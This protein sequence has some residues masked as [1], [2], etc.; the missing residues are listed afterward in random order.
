MRLLSLRFASLA[1]GL[2]LLPL[3]ALCL[4]CGALPPPDRTKL[5]EPGPKKDWAPPAVTT[6]DMP[7]GMKVWYLE[8]DQAPLISLQLVFTRGGTS[9]PVGKEGLTALM[10][11]MLDEGAGER[12]ALELSEAWQRLATDFGLGTDTDAV[13]A[14]LDMLADK[15]EPSL[16][17]LADVLRKPKLPAQ[18]FER[19]KAQRVAAKL[20][21][22]ADPGTVAWAVARRAVFGKGYR[23]YFN[24]GTKE[25]LAELSLDDV[26]ARYDAVIKPVGATF[27]VVGSVE[28]AVL[29]AALNKR[30]ADW[31]GSA[32]AKVRPVEDTKPEKGI[33]FVDFPGTTQ[34]TVIVLKRIGAVDSPDVFESTIFNRS[35]G[36]AFTSRLNLNLREEKGYTYGA[37]AVLSRSRHAGIYALYAKV[38]ADTTKASIDEMFKELAFFQGE[39]P[40]TQAEY[41]EAVGGL[42]NGFPGRFESLSGVAG[43]LADLPPNGRSSDW[44]QHWPKKVAG[45]TLEQARKTALGYTKGEDFTIIVAGDH[46]KLAP[47]LE[48]LKLPILLYQPNGERKAAQ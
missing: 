37:R 8:Q 25:S 5:P 3:F 13:V 26:K 33:H 27:V 21:Q 10:A 31:K 28:R 22:E 44:Y 12:S 35:L 29:Q 2:K 19:R 48:A 47:S 11:D 14:S 7:N 45:V 39:K 20:S 36:G 23:G 6:W 4:A 34:S 30:F 40:Q 38:K 15:L 42:L 43:Q 46:A 41:E 18:E 16:D 1:G 17:L 32:S 24:D 9:D